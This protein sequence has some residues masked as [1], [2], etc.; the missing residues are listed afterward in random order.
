MSSAAQADD[1][2]C[3]DKVANGSRKV[4]NQEQKKNRKCVKDGSADISACV[5][6]PNPKAT[7]AGTAI[8]ELFQTG[9]KCDPVPGLGV[10]SGGAPAGSDVGDGTIEKAG[11]ILRRVFGDP[12]DGIVAADKCLDKIAKRAGKKYDKELKAFRACVKA[13]APLASQAAVDA[14]V[15]TGVGDAKANDVQGKLLADMGKACAA[16][17][18]AGM[19]DG[20]C[21][22]CT[23]AA[24]CAACIGD[25]VDCA[26]CEA[27]NNSANGDADCDALDDGMANGSC[28]TVCG[29]NVK[30]ADEECD[31][32]DPGICPLGAGCFPAADP[33]ECECAPASCANVDANGAD[34]NASGT[35]NVTSAG[36][37]QTGDKFCGGNSPMNAFG[38][39]TVDLDCGPSPGSDL[40][41]V[42]A[43]WLGVATF[44]PFAIPAVSTTFTVTGPDAK[45]VHTATIPCVG[46]SDPCPGTPKLGAGFPCCTTPGFS[47][48]TFF[49]SALGFCSRVDQIACGDGIVDTSVP[50]LGDNDV[51]KAADTTTPNNANCTYD[52]TEVH[53]AC[54]PGTEDKLGTIAT[55]IGDGTFDTAGTHSRFSIPQRSVTWAEGGTPAPCN[56]ASLYDETDALITSFE[57]KLVTT[58]ASSTAAYVESPDDAD[59]VD[60]CGFGPGAFSGVAVGAP[61]LPGAG[62]LTVAVGAALSGGP[63]TLDLLFSAVTPLTSPVLV[64]PAPACVPVAPG[65]PE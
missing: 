29:D 17:P 1:A 63:P 37:P 25:I 41:C 42:A 43:P 26:A 11:D 14:C 22:S 6:A 21:S 27:M 4:G 7:D 53:P 57:L 40:Q 19:D 35:F 38:P 15:G 24:T 32:S 58:T 31:G 33:N 3:Q 50:M 12:V 28:G 48:G 34:A 60:F 49:I 61:D 65:C 16:F 10:N 13:G 44:A 59:T 9:G 36:A 8:E 2:K 56:P 5:N 30:D 18:A 45:C 20:D 51:A 55:T 64:A 23:D 52:G 62:S 54:V 46:S 39:C 47:V